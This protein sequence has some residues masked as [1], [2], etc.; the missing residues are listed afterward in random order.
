MHSTLAVFQF[1][2]LCF[3]A[4]RKM[5]HLMN[6]RE[7]IGSFLVIFLFVSIKK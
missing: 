1:F 6:V 2:V 7:F 4:W 3:Y 5:S